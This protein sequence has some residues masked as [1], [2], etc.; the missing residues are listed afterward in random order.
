MKKLIIL[1]GV[2]GAGKTHFSV[3]FA[4]EN[5]YELIN[6]DELFKL[7]DKDYQKTLKNFIKLVN[8][9]DKNIFCDGWFNPSDLLILKDRIVEKWLIYTSPEVCYKRFCK[10]V[11]I[12][13]PHGYSI[14]KIISIYPKVLLKDYEKIIDYTKE[15]KEN[16]PNKEIT[17]EEANAMFNSFIKKK[18]ECTELAKY[19]KDNF[20]YYYQGYKFDCG[21]ETLGLRG[22]NGEF[23]TDLS[24][25]ELLK[26]V[27]FKGK[28]VLDLGC[29]VGYFC[30]KAKENGATTVLGVENADRYLIV[31]NKIK[32]IVGSDVTFVKDDIAT[33]EYPKS[34]IIFLL[35]IIHHFEKPF[36][37][38]KKAFKKCNT[39]IVEL[40]LPWDKSKEIE[41]SKPIGKK[42][43]YRISINTMNKYA[44]SQGFKLTNQFN[45]EKLYRKFLIYEKKG[46]TN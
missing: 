28:S 27:D 9:S 26:Y 24:F 36:D 15:Y 5:N 12:N 8:A 7:Y 38:L 14:E 30:F 42:R 22:K 18:A 41:F 10:R 11:K 20:S 34:D 16:T 32:K 2:M 35:S 1:G 33:M 29:N 23:L 31:A 6:Y 13:N 45:S 44:N 37:L 21:V 4:K 3:R 46:D 17:K 40:D 39:L 19:I 25:R 43:L